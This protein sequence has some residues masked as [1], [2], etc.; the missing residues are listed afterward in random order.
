VLQGCGCGCDD[1]DG[2]LRASGTIEVVQ[3]DIAPM[4]AA[5]VTWLAVNEGDSVQAG[6][7]LVRLSQTTLASEIDL[8]SARVAAANA[9]LRDLQSGA[10]D[11][12][13]MRAESELHAARAESARAEAE[14]KRQ[15]A[16][17][18]AK[19]ISQSHF[20]AVQTA[21]ATAAS[22]VLSLQQSLNLLRLGSRQQ[23]IEAAEA[24]LQAARAA[25]QSTLALS[26][27][28]VLTAPAA[29]VVLGRHVES[30]EVVAPGVPALTIGNL[31]DPWVRVYVAAPSLPRLHVG[32]GALARLTGLDDHLFAGRIIAIDSRAQFTPRI[33]LTEDER[34]DLM[35]GVK[36]QLA[37]G[38]TFL[39]PGLPADVYFD[40]TGTGF[41]P[42]LSANRTV[43]PHS[44]SSPP[45]A[46]RGSSGSEG[47]STGRS[48]ARRST[49]SSSATGLW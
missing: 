34:A 41:P 17:L 2:V 42:E 15:S 4:M 22:R 33:A 8:R 13:I 48:A 35:F 16:L 3:T 11:P 25:L 27:D 45:P 44:I 43:H 21:A 23:R 49:R 32:Q 6:D 1:L 19:A 38:T 14:L 10:R 46:S 40:T 24:D 36:V 5:R 20:D 30:G 28:L 31:S 39:K 7:T 9:A 26:T 37:P 12:E 47:S 18:E 29:G